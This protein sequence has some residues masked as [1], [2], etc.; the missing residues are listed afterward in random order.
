MTWLW[1]LSRL[2]W[3]SLPPLCYRSKRA[4]RIVCAFFQYF[5]VPDGTTF[6]VGPAGEQPAV[7]WSSLPCWDVMSDLGQSAPDASLLQK[8]ISLAFAPAPGALSCQGW[9]LPAV[10]RPEFPR[11]SVA[12]PVGSRGEDGFCTR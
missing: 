3:K 12:V 7:P 6:G 5:H 2:V 10:V 8:R 4:L 11:Q 1:S 9:S